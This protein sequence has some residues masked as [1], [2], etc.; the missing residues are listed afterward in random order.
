VASSTDT[1]LIAVNTE[2]RRA[3]GD[4]AVDE[5]RAALTGAA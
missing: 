2:V 5:M 1:P 4:S 3:A